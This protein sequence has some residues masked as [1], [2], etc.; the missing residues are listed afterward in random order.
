MWTTCI[1]A[2]LS[3]QQ[4]LKE[5]TRAEGHYTEEAG[6]AIYTVLWHHLIVPGSAPLAGLVR[7][8]ILGIPDGC[9]RAEQLAAI[10]LFRQFLD[11]PDASFIEV[12][13]SL[14]SFIPLECVLTSHTL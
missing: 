11:L 10:A 13:S 3:W 12:D 4:M 2:G 9:E 1:D 14:P 5:L 7:L 6:V 8:G